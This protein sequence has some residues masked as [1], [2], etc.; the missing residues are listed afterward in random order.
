MERGQDRLRGLRARGGLQGGL[1][2][3]GVEYSVVCAWAWEHEPR[4]RRVRGHWA[5][6]K[7]TRAWV[8]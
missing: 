7:Q 1:R 4:R 2:L 6:V 5:T 8:P 3:R